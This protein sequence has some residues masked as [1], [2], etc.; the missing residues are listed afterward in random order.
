MGPI[1]PA[2]MERRKKSRHGYARGARGRYP[3]VAQE[4]GRGAVTSRQSQ[5]KDRN[6]YS[7]VWLAFEAAGNG[8]L[9]KRLV[10]TARVKEGQGIRW[11]VF[12]ETK[13]GP[14]NS[15]GH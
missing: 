10:S 7:G 5:D 14:V 4:L 15:R 9:S 3:Y 13:T 2:H 1:D 11:S 8:G 6:L 12:M